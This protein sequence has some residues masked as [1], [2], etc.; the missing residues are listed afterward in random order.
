METH[1][2]VGL[3]TTVPIE[4][5]YAAGWVPVDLNNVFITDPA[6]AK[7]VAAAEGRGFPRNMC[8]WIK[9]IYSTVRRLG[10]RRVVGVVQ[11][12]CSNTHGLMEVLQTEGVEVVEFAFPYNRDP[13]RLRQELEAFARAFGVT[14]A[15]AEETKQRLDR[16]RS[17]IAEIDRL[18][19]E[20]DR[21]HGEE[22]HL[23]LVQT[24]DLQGQ[25]EAYEQAAEAFLA[26]ARTRRPIESRFRLGL[27]GIPPILSDLHAWLEARGARIVF[28]EMARQFS[29]PGPSADLV[30]QYRNYTYPYDVFFRIEDIRRECR[31]RRLDGLIHYVQSFCF[32]QIQDLVIRE[33]IDLPILTLEADRPG[34]LDAHLETRLEAFLEMLG[35]P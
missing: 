3:T 9:G 16:A 14:L 8:S 12:D 19:W 7:L 10:L 35:E 33:K 11:G 5:I 30:E 6:P 28:N 26:E 18:T 24:S 15:A 34:P 21:V 4:V 29:M 31:R 2:K 13:D 22:N 27:L 20:G 23:W 17:K 32:R 25:P 1:R